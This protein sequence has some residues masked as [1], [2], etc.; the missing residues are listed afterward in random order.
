[1]RRVLRADAGLEYLVYVPSTAM[2]NGPL[3]V[4]I[5]GV[6]RNADQHARLLAGYAEACGAVLVAP[7]FNVEQYPDYQRLGRRG[8]GKRADMALNMIVAEVAATT[9]A[10]GDKVHLFG[11]SGGA[12]FA[13]RYFMAHPHRVAAAVLASAGWY[14]LPEP[15]RRFPHGTRMNNKLPDLR[16]DAEEFLGVPVTVMVGASDHGQQG[17]R[18]APRLDR[19]QGTSRVERAR[20]WVAAMRAA[21][22]QHHLE[23]R[24]SYMELE[25]CNHSFSRSVLRGGL[26][27]QAFRA[28]FGELPA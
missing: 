9:G 13:N 28:L 3:C 5:H 10:A 21:A 26:G 19:E 23:C 7:I 12:Q 24:V 2:R 16:F 11:F 8:R 4:T 20:R 1:M 14:T 22:L 15:T 27:E 6:S 17:L 25:H 18:R